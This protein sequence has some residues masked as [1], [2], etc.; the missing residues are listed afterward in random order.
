MKKDRYIKLTESLLERLEMV[1]DVKADIKEIDEKTGIIYVSITFTNGI[2]VVEKFRKNIF[3]SW[4]MEHTYSYLR[5]K[6]VSFWR[7]MIYKDEQTKQ[8][9]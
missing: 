5:N 9:D 6:I 3:D 2:E 4:G 8:K 7:E 1:L